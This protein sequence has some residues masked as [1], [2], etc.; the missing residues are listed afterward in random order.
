MQVTIKSSLSQ[1]TFRTPTGAH[2]I[3]PELFTYNAISE[4]ITIIY[5]QSVRLIYNYL[6]TKSNSFWDVMPKFLGNVL[7]PSSG[8]KSKACKQAKHSACIAS[9]SSLVHFH[10][11]VPISLLEVITDTDMIQIFKLFRSC[12]KAGIFEYNVE[13]TV[14]SV[15]SF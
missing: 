5:V 14:F 9:G 3:V 13:P 7:P 4:C 6:I 15:H 8:S 11:A 2:D 10:P 12:H 1:S